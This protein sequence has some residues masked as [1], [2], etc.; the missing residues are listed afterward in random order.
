MFILITNRGKVNCRKFPVTNWPLIWRGHLGYWNSECP[1]EWRTPGFFHNHAFAKQTTS[2]ACCQTS[3]SSA[4]PE[5]YIPGTYAHSAAYIELQNC[6]FSFNQHES[7]EVCKGKFERSMQ[8]D[9]Q[10]RP[11]SFTSG[12]P[13]SRITSSKL[14]PSFQAA[15]KAFD[16]VR[17]IDML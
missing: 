16:H 15:Y 7:P 9:W 5:S 13:N 12:S 4:T 6:V 17:G 2:R 11:P 1:A 10:T 3:N 8:N 14:D